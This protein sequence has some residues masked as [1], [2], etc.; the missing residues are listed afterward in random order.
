VPLSLKGTQRGDIYLEMTFFAAG[1][2]PLNCCPSKF[3][4]PAERLGNP[5]S[6]PLP[7]APARDVPANTLRPNPWWTG[8]PSQ[9]KR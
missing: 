8:T 9:L 3:T 1:P 2:A 4:N 7:N 6:R 5:N